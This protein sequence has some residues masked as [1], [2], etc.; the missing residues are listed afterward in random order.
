MTQELGE[1]IV[2][3]VL[4]EAPGR[5]ALRLAPTRE[6]DVKEVYRAG[7]FVYWNEYRGLLEDKYALETSLERSARRLALVVRQELGLALAP[8]AALEWRGV[9]V[10]ARAAVTAALF[11]AAQA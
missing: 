1:L 5:L 11:G 4:L 9:D 6:V 8:A 10:S 3:A 7:L 2:E